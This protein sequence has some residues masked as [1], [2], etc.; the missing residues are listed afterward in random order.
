MRW[1]LVTHPRPLTLNPTANVWLARPH[2]PP[3]HPPPSLHGTPRGAK[4][5]KTEAMPRQG[6]GEGWAQGARGWASAQASPPGPCVGVRSAARALP[7]LGLG[8]EPHVLR[9]AG[10]V[11]R[12][13]T[14]TS[15]RQ[16][17]RSCS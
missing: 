13:G 14:G 4:R 11:W 9:T 2:G 12:W 3:A 6:C 8:T 10:P 15:S 16:R 5:E 7:C 1:P 17:A